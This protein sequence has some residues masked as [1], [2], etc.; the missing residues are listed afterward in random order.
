MQQTPTTS[1]SASVSKRSIAARQRRHDKHNRNVQ[2]E[3]NKLQRSEDNIIPKT[4]FARIVHE[5]LD[6]HGDYSIRGEAMRA[7]Q[8]ATEA[9]VTDMF[10]EA[11]NVA[12]YSGRETVTDRDIQFTGPGNLALEETACSELPLIAPDQ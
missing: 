3:I 4:S 6:S 5:V 8:C 9:C 10:Q 7:L 2:R 11:N 12:L 1:T